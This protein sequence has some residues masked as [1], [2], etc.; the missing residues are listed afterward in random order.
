MLISLVN[1]VTV[2][3]GKINRSQ[4]FDEP[5]SFS[6]NFRIVKVP[7]FHG[8]DERLIFLVNNFIVLKACR[9]CR[10]L[11]TTA[12]ALYTWMTWLSDNNVQALDEGKYKIVSP[13]YGFRQFLLDRVIEQKTLSSTTANSYIL[14]IK[15]FYQMLDEE[16]LIKQELFFKRRLSV[17]D[18]FRKITA[19]DLTIPSPRSN[20]LNPLTKSEFSHFIQL[21]ELESPPFRLAIKLMLFSGLRLGEALSFPC[22]LI[23][24]STLAQCEDK[25]LVR[26]LRIGPS[27]GTKT[28]FSKERD[29][30][31]TTRLANEILNF[32][33]G[34]KPFRGRLFQSNLGRP[35]T[36]CAFYSSWYRL[37]KKYFDCFGANFNHKP[38]DLRATFA[39]SLLNIAINE[40]GVSAEIAL[41]VTRNFMGHCSEKTTLRYTNYI[42]D[43]SVSNKVAEVVDRLVFEIL[44]GRSYD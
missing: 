16:K 34:K 6:S 13:T 32:E 15:S 21:I 7:L 9:G 3:V 30:F 19:S 44:E 10:D 37:K 39:T 1:D 26:G 14:V 28:K 33:I 17:I 27:N 25:Y 42:N 40:V 24:E 38:H 23:T 36:K 43:R 8:F 5:L 11:S 29:L 35:Y 4:S 41:D 20:P 18:G 12:K 2:R 22:A 31:L